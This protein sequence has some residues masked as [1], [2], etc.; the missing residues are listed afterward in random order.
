[1]SY[2]FTLEKDTY[3][4]TASI[5]DES[6]L[7]LNDVLMQAYEHVDDDE[8]LMRIGVIQEETQRIISGRLGEREEDSE[9]ARIEARLIK[10]G[11]MIVTHPNRGES[12][13]IHQEEI[14]NV[15]I[16][17][18]IKLDINR[19]LEEVDREIDKDDGRGPYEKVRPFE[20]L[21]VWICNAYINCIKDRVEKELR[22][23]ATEGTLTRRM[24]S[25]HMQ[26][27]KRAYP[28]PNLVDDY[29][30]DSLW[31]KLQDY[32]PKK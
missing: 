4:F 13:V 11:Q 9:E 8:L 12:M 16:E 23:M 1:M 22:G 32:M 17:E 28:G 25:T 2:S 19:Q 30:V 10:P 18:F 3:D 6:V 31:L 21:R 29:G 15:P 7:E 27:A 14:G 26:E 5:D 24:V 20:N